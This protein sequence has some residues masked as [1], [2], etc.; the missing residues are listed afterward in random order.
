MSIIQS[1][2]KSS[3]EIVEVEQL[4]AGSYLVR[5]HEKCCR[6]H[7]S[8]VCNCSTPSRPNF[9]DDDA[10]Q[11]VI[12]H[13]CKS[14]PPDAQQNIMRRFE[15]QSRKDSQEFEKWQSLLQ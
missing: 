3:K 5:L 8:R 1:F 9:V 11:S 12:L 6:Y 10:I 15:D 7:R 14:L 4:P 13:L 2:R